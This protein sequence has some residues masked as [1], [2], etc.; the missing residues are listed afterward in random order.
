MK[1]LS[2]NIALCCFD[3]SGCGN[4]EGE[5]VSLGVHEQEDLEAVLGYLATVGSITEVA[6]W[7]R[8]MGAVTALLFLPGCKFIRAVVV[9][10]PFASF[11]QL[12]EDMAAQTTNI[13]KM[14]LQPALKLLKRTVKEK[15]DFSLSELNPLKVVPHL[16]LPAFFIVAV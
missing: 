7:G 14:M 4:A 12:V 10:S 9:D 16:H 5:Y 8:S 11:K 6:L 13:P 3:F 2:R 1:L 15:A